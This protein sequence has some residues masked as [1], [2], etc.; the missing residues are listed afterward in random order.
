MGQRITI[1][2]NDDLLKKLREI[3]A[4][5]IMKN[6][7]SGNYL[8]SPSFSRIVNDALRKGLTK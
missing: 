5:I 6:A 4:K 8:P 2:M 1:V 3:Q 7:K